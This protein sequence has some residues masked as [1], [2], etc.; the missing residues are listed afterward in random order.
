MIKEIDFSDDWQTT[1]ITLEDGRTAHVSTEEILGHE[2]YN[3]GTYQKV[4]TDDVIVFNCPILESMRTIEEAH[5]L[6]VA[7]GV[8]SV[9]DDTLLEAAIKVLAT[10][11]YEVTYT[12]YRGMPTTRKVEASTKLEAAFLCRTLKVQ[13]INLITKLQVTTFEVVEVAA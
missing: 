10:R 12:G 4:Y 7:E 9:E 13:S 8:D 11:A 2:V 6:D 1:I 3:D 5:Y